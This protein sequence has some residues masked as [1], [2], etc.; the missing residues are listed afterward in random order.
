MKKA[1]TFLLLLSINLLAAQHKKDINL[2]D[3]DSTWGKEIFP[4]PLSFAQD[5][6]YRGIEEARFPP[7]GWS[8]AAHPNFWSYTFVWK[9]DKKQD[10]TTNVLEENL[11]KYFDGL[12]RI[13]TTEELKHYKTVALFIKKKHNSFTGKIKTYDRFTTKKQL[14]L[15]VLVESNFCEKQQKSILLF[16]F[17]PKGFTHPTWKMLEKIELTSNSCDE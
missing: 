6:N 17:S 16:K 10:V 9:I 1:I 5:I 13:N 12:M 14:I 4:F 7:K 3:L 2:I 8:D 11:Q 15:N